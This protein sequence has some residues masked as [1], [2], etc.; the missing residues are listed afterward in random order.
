MKNSV[1]LIVILVLLFSCKNNTKETKADLVEVEKINVPKIVEQ[2]EV[3]SVWAANGVGFDLRTVGNNQFVAYYDSNRMMTVASREIGSGKW[4]KKTLPNQLMWDSHNSVKLG[5]DELGYIHVS[6]NQHVHPLAYFISTEPF[7]INTMVEVNNMVGED[8]D[9]VTYPNFFHDKTGSLLFSYRSGTCGNG[10]ILI[11]RFLPE[12]QQW[13]RYL[14]QPLFE[15]IEK[16]DDRAAY[17]KWVKDA[18]GDF[19]FIWMWR[20]TPMVE[21]SHNICYAK[22]SDLKNWKNAAGEIVTLPFRPD[23]EKVMVDATPSKGGMHNNRYKLILSENNEPIIGYVKYDEEG[24]TQLYLA[25]F[26]EGNWVSMKISNW[27][28]RW[29]FIDGGA[30]MSIGGQFDFVGISQD[31]V[32]AIDWRT[33]KGKSG[34]YTIDL[35]TLEYTD[36]VAKIQLKYPENIR[37]PMTNR[38]G[39]NVR[40]AYDKG[41]T[42][43]DGS[44]YVLKWEAKHGG[45]KQ[46]APDII[47]EGPLSKLVLLKIN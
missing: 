8:E 35:E 40:M 31:G 18:N 2:I 19:H 30:F 38:D 5:V 36:K 34:R 32:L 16:D 22:T 4:Q 11:N 7:D 45:F 28:F 27:D 9:S 3:D 26:I 20:W 15:G 42:Q 14:E 23:D 41:D 44:R 17:H 47:P 39:M 13:E 46:H 6:G 1:L 10:N 37:K 24:M 25:K 43:E 21:T 12:E 33:E 29:K